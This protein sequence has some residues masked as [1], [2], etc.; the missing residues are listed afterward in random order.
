MFLYLCPACKNGHHDKCENTQPREK[1]RAHWNCRCG[2]QNK[3]P[4]WS[5]EKAIKKF[6]EAAKERMVRGETLRFD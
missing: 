5:L 3:D 4:N 6:D 2:C 1:A